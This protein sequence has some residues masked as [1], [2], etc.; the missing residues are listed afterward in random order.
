MF[1]LQV[2]VFVSCP[3]L[4]LDLHLP[5]ASTAEKN[6]V[7]WRQRYKELETS[8][9]YKELELIEDKS[10]VYPDYYL[11]PFHAYE[12]GNLCWQVRVVKAVGGISRPVGW[13]MVHF[14]ASLHTLPQGQVVSCL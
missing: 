1:V 12:K 4:F 6:G 11:Q 5:A 8:D 2:E 7:P 13:E 3:P 10:I 9:V 14:F